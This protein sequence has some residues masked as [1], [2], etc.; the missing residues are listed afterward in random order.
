MTVEELLR[1]L[2]DAP[3]SS[4]VRLVLETEQIVGELYHEAEVVWWDDAR[5]TTFIGDS[6]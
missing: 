2:S 4:T 1:A 3:K 6:V 5:A